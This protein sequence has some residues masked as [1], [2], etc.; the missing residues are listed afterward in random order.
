MAAPSPGC[1]SGRPSFRP[2]LRAFPTCPRTLSSSLSRFPAAVPSL[3]AAFFFPGC[4]GSPGKR[5]E[6]GRAAAA[7][8]H[9]LA[10]PRQGPRLRPAPPRHIHSSRRLRGE[11]RERRERRRKGAGGGELLPH[12]PPRQRRHRP[13][14]LGGGGKG[15]CAPRLRGG[16]GAASRRLHPNRQQLGWR[17]A[18]ASHRAR[19][20]CGPTSAATGGAGPGVGRE[21]LAAAEASRA[22]RRVRPPP[23]PAGG[24][25]PAALQQPKVGALRTRTPA[26]SLP[27]PET[28]SP[29]ASAGSAA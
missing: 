29:L 1:P 17:P 9:E 26:A 28:E 7:S 13:G 21:G 25:L 2:S 6:W 22:K 11:G 20:R 8:P 12:R 19:G 3:P 4:G 23:A 18:R 10:G 27:A 15:G 24:G 14:G 5:R 16:G